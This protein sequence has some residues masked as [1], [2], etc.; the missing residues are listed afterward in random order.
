M[1][2]SDAGILC[3]F[4]MF[5]LQ[6]HPIDGCD[7]TPVSDANMYLAEGMA[8]VCF[9]PFLPILIDGRF[10]IA[11][12]ILCWELVSKRNS[13]WTLHY[14][15]SARAITDVPDRVRVANEPP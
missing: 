3:V 12:R 7:F 15:K 13:D 4:R 1:H 11:D 14:V 10:S 6:L 2:G 5:R 9:L 8:K